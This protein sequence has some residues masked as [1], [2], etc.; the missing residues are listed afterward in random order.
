MDGS[1]GIRPVARN[2]DRIVD[3]LNVRWRIDQS[4]QGT[5]SYQSYHIPYELLLQQPQHGNAYKAGIQQH[6][7]AEVDDWN[8][9]AGKILQSCG[10]HSSR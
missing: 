7:R 6:L 3:G 4:G 10:D 9:E 8:E 1:K 5:L 2:V